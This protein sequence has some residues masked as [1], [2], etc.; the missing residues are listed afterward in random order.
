MRQWPDICCETV[1]A[2]RSQDGGFVTATPSAT[3]IT[4]DEYL[5]LDEGEIKHEYID[6]VAYAMAGG[7]LE[8][9]LI[10]TNIAGH[11]RGVLRERPC[12]V[13]TSDARLAVE[14]TRLRT[15]P[16]VTVVC[17]DVSRT[18]RGISMTNP[19]VVVEV[20]SP[21]TE[22][23]DRGGKFRHYRHVASLRE[24][25]VVSSDERLVEHHIRGDRGIWTLRDVQEGTVELGSIA[26]TLPLEEIYLKVD[27]TVTPPA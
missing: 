21:G 26:C 22:G 2:L 24:Y 27:L 14:A 12:Q 11:L 13:Y 18:D 6:G 5:D 8:H 10:A 4:I 9:S 25:L 23:W 1:G 7:T 17:G 3:R 20:A 19:I 15:Y 16:D